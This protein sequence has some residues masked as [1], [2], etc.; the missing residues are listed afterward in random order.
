MTV[1]TAFENENS[2]FCYCHK[3][4]FFF[5]SESQLQEDMAVGLLLL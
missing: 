4:F 3:D 2:V 5:H 1:Q